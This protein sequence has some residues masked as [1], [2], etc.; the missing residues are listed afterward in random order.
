MTQVETVIEAAAAD[1]AVGG[2]LR[3]VVVADWAELPVRE[4]VRAPVEGVDL[5]VVR[6]DRD[7]PGTGGS[8]QDRAVAVF[9]GRCPHRGPRTG[10]PRGW[11]A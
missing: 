7:G 11:P 10:C 9:E 6:L 1:Q 2:G 5:V 4:P 8:G 3:E